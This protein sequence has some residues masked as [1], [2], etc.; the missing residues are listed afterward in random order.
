MAEHT[1]KNWVKHHADLFGLSQPDELRTLASWQVSLLTHSGGKVEP[2]FTAS[3]T[4]AANP[5]VLV[6]SPGKFLN[7]MTA[8]LLTLIYLLGGVREEAPPVRCNLCGGIGLVTGLPHPQC[9]KEGKWIAPYRDLAM[10]CPC[11][12]ESHFANYEA[13]NPNW[14]QQVEERKAQVA[15]E[16]RERLEKEKPTKVAK[17][18]DAILGDLEDMP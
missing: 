6:E 15:A 17:A 12:G 5:T 13:H 7:K 4:I 10:R 9:L 1:Y 8:H 2:L 14:R 18:V 11:R 16:L 3:D